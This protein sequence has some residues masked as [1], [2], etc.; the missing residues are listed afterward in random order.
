MTSLIE[1]IEKCLDLT[2]EFKSKLTTDI[3]CMEGMSGLKTRHFYNNLCS[4]DD[5]RYLEIGVWKGSTF[6]SALCGNALK[7]VAIDNF[8]EFVGSAFGDPRTEFQTNF[9]NHKG[10]NDATF[11]ETNCWELDVDALKNEHG[12]FNI[13]M[14]DGNHTETSHYEALNHYLP[15]LDDTFIYVV[16]DWNFPAIEKGTMASIEKN[17]VDIVYQKVILTEANPGVQRGA[18]HW[19]NGISIFVLKK[20]LRK[21]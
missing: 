17:G 11:I 21:M 14:Y 9:R 6:C 19:H 2:E 4:M 15:C 16:D 1:H 20:L 10:K 13:Y 7:A 8:S 12:T 5:A 3:A 18:N